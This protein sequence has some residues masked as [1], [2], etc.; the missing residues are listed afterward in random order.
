M[1]IRQGSDQGSK[2]SDMLYKGGGESPF[3]LIHPWSMEPAVGDS[4]Q[5]R[6]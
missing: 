4:V 6:A 5:N 2:I 3:P 1:E